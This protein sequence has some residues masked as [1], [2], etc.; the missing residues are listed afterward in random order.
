LR[1]LAPARWRWEADFAITHAAAH[2]SGG[3]V[4]ACVGKLAFAVLAEAH[5]RAAESGAWVINEKGLTRRT[6]LEA[7]EAMLITAEGTAD[8]HRLV[9]EIRSGL[10]RA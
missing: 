4:A 2:A 6:E 3:D 8:L 1:D 7:A 9:D 10:V 5:A